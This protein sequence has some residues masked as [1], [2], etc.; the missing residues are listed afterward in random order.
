MDMPRTT[1]SGAQAVS[2]PSGLMTGM[3][4]KMAMI[5]K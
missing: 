5:R 1:I 3:D 4:C 2:G